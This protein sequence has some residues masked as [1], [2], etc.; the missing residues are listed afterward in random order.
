[1]KPN[2]PSFI[3]LLL[4]L[5]LIYGY[6]L[7]LVVVSKKKRLPGLAV[8]YMLLNLFYCSAMMTRGKYM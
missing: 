3:E 1:M 7:Y 6:A 5:V 2:N 8:S 4:K